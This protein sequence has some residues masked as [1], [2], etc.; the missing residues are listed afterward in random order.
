ML[1]SL[2]RQLLDEG[3]RF[4]QPLRAIEG[5]ERQHGIRLLMAAQAQALEAL[6]AAVELHQT[7][8]RGSLA[9]ERGTAMSEV[10][11]PLT[12]ALRQILLAFD[13]CNRTEI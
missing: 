8:L 3:S 5:G 1:R 7:T 13:H 4:T 11:Q 12:R 2:Y 6:Y 9:S 10:G